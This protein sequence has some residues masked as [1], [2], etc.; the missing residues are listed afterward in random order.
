MNYIHLEEFA[1]YEEYAWNIEFSGAARAPS[2]RSPDRAGDLYSIA[3]RNLSD[4]IEKKWARIRLLTTRMF[5]SRKV[6]QIDP[7]ESAWLPPMSAG[8]KYNLPMHFILF[9]AD[10]WSN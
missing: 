10:S 8:R 9:H 6:F 2:V 3:R 5:Y 4:Y 7:I 1:E